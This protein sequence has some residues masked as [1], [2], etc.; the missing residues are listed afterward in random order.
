MIITLIFILFAIAFTCEYIDVTTGMGYGTLMG[1]ILLIFGF[2]IAQVV[3]V[4]LLAQMICGAS[5]CLFHQKLKNANFNPLS[6]DAKDSRKALLFTI[7]GSFAMVGALF[8]VVSIPEFFLMLYLGITISVVGIIM[9][10]QKNFQFSSKLL[11]VVGGISA[12]NK[13]IS[14]GGFGPVVTS[15]QV[16]TGSETSNAVA[17]TSFSETAL[18]ALGF[19]LYLIFVGGLDI[20]LAFLVI[21]SGLLATP[22]GAFHAKKLANKK[23][24]NKIIGVTIVVLG[25]MTLLKC[26]Y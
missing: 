2:S 4:L 12:F 15:G 13:A 10:I 7:C 20:Y 5:A 9:L 3:P 16:I 6:N 11:L 19:I 23:S 18:S 24:A 14:G 25:F 1:P 8:L 21:F 22:L 17:I 26:F